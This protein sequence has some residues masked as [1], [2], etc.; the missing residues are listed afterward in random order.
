MTKMQPTGP[1]E[2]M[3]WVYK[4]ELLLFIFLID[5]YS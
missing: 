1:G 3:L 2:D 5:L 4:P